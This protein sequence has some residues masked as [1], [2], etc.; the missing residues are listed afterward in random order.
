MPHDRTGLLIIRVWVEDGSE[1]PLR[2]SVRHTRD[3][4]EGFQ[5][6]TTLTDPDATAQVVR[7]WLRDVLTR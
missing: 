4:A 6:A 1:A 2:A 5:Y 7:L 3:V